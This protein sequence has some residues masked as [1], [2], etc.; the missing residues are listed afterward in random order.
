MDVAQ[1]LEVGKEGRQASLDGRP[2]P[3]Q[4]A[5]GSS[6]ATLAVASVVVTRA[7]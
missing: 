2:E 4:L 5:L 7:V 1:V 6:S 3:L